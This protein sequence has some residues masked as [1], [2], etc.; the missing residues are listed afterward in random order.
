MSAG[1]V[2]LGLAGAALVGWGLVLLAGL[3]GQLLEI[4][5]WLAGGI[6]VHDALLAPLVLL[7]GALAARRVPSWLRPPLVRLLVVLGP[8]TLVA[9]PVLGRF[10]ARADNPTLLDRPYLAGWLVVAALAVL[11]TALDA[12]RRRRAVAGPVPP[13]TP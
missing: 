1:R 11:G 7:L 12:A 13:P 9:V 5:A 2:V 8:L 3:S 4:A 10:G 6:V